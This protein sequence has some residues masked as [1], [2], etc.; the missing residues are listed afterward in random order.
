M[1]NL[2]RY[3]RSEKGFTMIEMMIVLIIIGVLIAGGIWLYF[4]YIEGAKVTKAKAYI[5]TVQGQLDAYYA[6][7]S[8]YPTTL[9]ELTDA[10]VQASNASTL[11]ATDPW[12]QNYKYNSTDG[13]SY[14]VETGYTNVQGKGKA[15]VGTGAN[16]QST[17]PEV[18]TP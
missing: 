5:T 2:K 9:D 12:G 15:V 13:K 16:G 6:E 7:K 1:L 4:G 14:K 18:A 17:T 3:L 8:K 10:G 11:T